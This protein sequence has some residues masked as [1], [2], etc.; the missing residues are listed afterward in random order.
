MAAKKVAKKGKRLHG[1]K[2]LRKQKT[3]TLTPA[4]PSPVPMPYP[5]MS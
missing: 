2:A 5:N 3:L 1:G 4:A